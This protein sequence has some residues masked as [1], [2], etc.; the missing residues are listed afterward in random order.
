MADRLRSAVRAGDIVAR[1]G[2][3]EFVVLAPGL[4]TAED[5]AALGDKLLA[6]VSQPFDL[7][8]GSVQV[9]MTVGY[10]LAPDDGQAL[11]ALGLVADRAMYDGKQAGKGC[12]VRGRTLEPVAFSV[13]SAG[14]ATA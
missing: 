5:A 12:V 10:A 9:G 6:T 4:A 8:V 2:G 3:D 13:P 11:Q 7:A 1:T 14:D